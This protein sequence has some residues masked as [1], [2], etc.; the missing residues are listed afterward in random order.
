[1]RR[2]TKSRIIIAWLLLITIMPLFVV[3]TFHYH[4]SNTT[5]KSEKGHSHNDPCGQ[6]LICQFTLSPFTQTESF[7]MHVYVSVI[8][9]EPACYADKVA[10]PCCI[11]ITCAPHP[12]YLP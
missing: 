2:R 11:L 3:K 1:M 4:E 10:S 6:C 7:Q 8:D 12:L 5:A 9:Y